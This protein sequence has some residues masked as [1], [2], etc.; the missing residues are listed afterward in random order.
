MVSNCFIV[1][2]FC[3]Y[4][5]EG[6]LITWMIS[7]NAHQEM[8]T[9]LLHAVQIESPGIKPKYIMSDKDHAQMNSIQLVYPESQL[10]LCWW[11]VLHAWQQHF[12]TLQHPE[13]WSLLKA[14]VWITDQAAIDMQ[15]EAIKHVA[16]ASV[17]WYLETN[18]WAEQNLWSVVNCRDW[19]VLKLSDMNMLVEAKVQHFIIKQP[20]K[21]SILSWHHCHESIA[22]VA[23]LV[24]SRHCLDQWANKFQVHFT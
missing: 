15:W 20:I 24:W 8:I 2:L 21:L 11:H 5:M 10:L 12:V 13:P 14:W 6:M 18:W 16:P 3:A 7:S 9:F 22:L 23:Q 4:Q 19:S 1:L 17:I